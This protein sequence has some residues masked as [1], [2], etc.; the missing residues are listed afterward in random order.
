MD[1]NRTNRQNVEKGLE[2]FIDR[3]HGNLGATIRDFSKTCELATYIVTP[4]KI[5]TP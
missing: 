4:L 2:G 5:V 1:R 3:D